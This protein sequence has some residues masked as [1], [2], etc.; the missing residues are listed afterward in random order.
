M[1]L[2]L[3]VRAFN[4]SQAVRIG[5]QKILPTKTSYIDISDPVVRKELG[6]H[7]AIGAVFAVGPVS[8][9]NADAVVVSGGVVSAGS[10]LSVNVS[11]G[12]LRNRQTAIHV[13]G[14]SATNT[15]LTAAHASL[16]RVDL[17]HWDATTGAVGKTDGTPAASASAPATPAGKVPLATV[18]V[19]A[20][21]TS[22]GT[23]TDVRPRG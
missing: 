23:I 3:P 12:E 15:A 1:A 11:A 20:T 19:A 8:A 2:Y 14:A 13:A 21:A 17:I 6:Y 7:S 9:S 22:P 16:N 10:G 18:A 4:R 5:K